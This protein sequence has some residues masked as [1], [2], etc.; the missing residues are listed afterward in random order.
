M[1]PVD[2]VKRNKHYR[3]LEYSH[4]QQGE[5]RLVACGMERCDPDA[6]FGPELRDC[7]H[8]HAVLS[9]RGTLKTRD[10]VF[11]PRYGQ[12]F[13]LRDGEEVEYYPD[14]Q[15]PWEYCWVTFTGSE[16]PGIAEAIGFSPEIYCL[17]S[18]VE[19]REFFALVNRIY[20]YPEMNAVGDLR[21]RGV[22]LEFLAL[23]ME[24]VADDGHRRPVRP[25]TNECEEY[26][27]LA[28]EFIR[29]NYYTITV[30]EVV[31]YIGFSRGYLSTQFR[32]HT[33]QTMQGY[34]MRIRADAAIKLLEETEMSIQEI[35]NK[36]GY[37]DQL[38]FS[39][40]FKGICG[41]SPKHYRER[42]QI[43]AEERA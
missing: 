5:L 18:E 19:T 34:L 3:C 24:A 33:G 22:L 21:R 17:D 1:K 4:D 38:A 40:M 20:Q 16:A 9:G 29:N 43:E 12:L 41:V 15:D 13:L 7:W 8:L 39:R 42:K 10:R 25:K 32:R 2:R 31:D 28:A 35:A 27:R 11:H 6:R 36:V 26:V 14:A 23:A 30:E 37:E